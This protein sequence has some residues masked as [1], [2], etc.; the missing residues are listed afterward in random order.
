MSESKLV[1]EREISKRILVMNKNQENWTGVNQRKGEKI[2]NMFERRIFRVL[3]CLPWIIIIPLSIRLKGFLSWVILSTLIFFTTISSKTFFP[4][5]ESSYTRMGKENKI[6]GNLKYFFPLSTSS[7][8]E[9][10]LHLSPF[11]PLSIS[12]FLFCI[13]SYRMSPWFYFFTSF[14]VP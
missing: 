10:T 2:Q 12:F 11:L 7:P 9:L 3:S 1:K 5:S 13:F 6:S 4:Q 14:P 8:L